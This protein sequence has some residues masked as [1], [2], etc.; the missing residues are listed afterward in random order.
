MDPLR[1]LLALEDALGQGQRLAELLHPEF[2]E[3]GRSGRRW[4]REAVL[5][6]LADS[7]APP[8]AREDLELRPL[9]PDLVQLIWRSPTPRAAWRCSIWQRQ[10]EG[11]RLRFHQA[12]PIPA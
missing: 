2:L 4:T 10:P 8:P 7:G 6:E 9:A 3:F 11:W 1:E 12:T 5:A